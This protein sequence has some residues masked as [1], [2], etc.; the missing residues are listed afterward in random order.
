MTKSSKKSLSE[1]S[2]PT[3]VLIP[4]ILGLAVVAYLLYRN[5]DLEQFRNLSW[6]RRTIFYIG[7]AIVVYMIRHV[8]LSYRLMIMS[9]HHFSFKKSV[10]LIFIWEF[11]SAISPTSLGGSATATIF[12]AQEK[13]SAARSMTIVIYSIVLDT[14]YF[15]V[16]FIFLIPIVG[17]ILVYPG[18]ESIFSSNPYN[19]SFYIIMLFMLSYG[20]FFFYG[21]FISPES[22]QKTLNWFAKRKLLRRWQDKIEQT[23]SD[24]TV[25]S[26]QLR[27]KGTQFHVKNSILT[28]V[29]WFCKFLTVPLLIFAIAQLVEF[30]LF[31]TLKM[32]ARNQSMYAITAFSP[33]PGSAGVAEVVFANFYSDYISK[34]GATFIAIIW[35]LMTYYVYLFAGFIILPLW[36][37]SIMQRR[38]VEK[39]ENIND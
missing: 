29:A 8:A 28:G 39:L 19:I 24:I 10:Q 22:I 32:T 1:V 11:A 5:F 31:E 9:D 4:I 16:T 38:K 17:A 21:L 30:D 18:V 6:N 37:K 12:L 23:A 3:K 26:K 14:L 20:V 34:T 27:T 15:I 2:K 25:S 35:R 7:L 33:T 36:I 13:L